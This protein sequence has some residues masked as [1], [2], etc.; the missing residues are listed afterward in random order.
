M[1]LDYEEKYY[2]QGIKFIVGVDEAGRGPL[3]GPVVAGAV[4]LSPNFKSELIN[5]SKKLSAKKRNEVYKLIVENALDYGVGIVSAKEIDEINIY[6]ASRLAMT[7]AI[8][9]LIHPYEMILSDA[10][11]LPDL[12]CPVEAIIK[13]DA[14]ASCIAAASIVAKVTRDKLMDKLDEKYPQYGIKNHKGYPTKEHLEALEKYG[15][16][17]KEH[18][19]T[20]RPLKKEKKKIKK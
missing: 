18:R 9:K 7:R 1:T 11:P 2:K 15:P 13:G 16:I 12:T 17:E 4:I 14:K 5:D 20:Y 8:E 3:L 10:M 19:F 6:Q